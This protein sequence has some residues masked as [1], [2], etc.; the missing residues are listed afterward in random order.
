MP[1]IHAAPLSPKGGIHRYIRWN[2]ELVQAGYITLR[3]E[4]PAQ[5]EA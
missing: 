5:G 2:M 1:A 4:E 3:L